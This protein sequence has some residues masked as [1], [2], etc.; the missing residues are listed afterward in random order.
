M[1]AF[2]PILRALLKRFIISFLKP[3]RP[4]FNH[5]VHSLKCLICRN[6]FKT[7]TLATGTSAVL[8]Q[9]PGVEKEGVKIHTNSRVFSINGN[10]QADSVSLEGGETLPADIVLAQSPP[11]NWPMKPAYISQIGDR[12]GSM[13]I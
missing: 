4:E 10:R 6:S 8:P 3:T 1:L 11:S 12:S 9:I 13:I 2:M 5:F 7:H